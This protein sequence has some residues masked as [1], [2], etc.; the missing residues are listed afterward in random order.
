VLKYK[1]KVVFQ[2]EERKSIL[3]HIKWVDEIVDDTP[4]Y[5]TLEWLAQH[6][7]DYVVGDENAYAQ[8][9]AVPFMPVREAG[10]FISMPREEGTPLLPF[11][12][13]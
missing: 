5:P 9:E 4:W 3:E 6:K 1:G 7:I 8:Y 13:A 11:K 2:Y 10:R 12:E